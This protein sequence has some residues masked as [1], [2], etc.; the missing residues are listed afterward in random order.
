MQ[1]HQLA[2]AKSIKTKKRVG[3]GGKRGTYAGRGGKGQSARAGRNFRP[4]IRDVLKR[5]PKLRGHRNRSAANIVQAANLAVLEAKFKT[6]DKI[7]PRLLLEKGVICR[8][9]G[10][11]PQVKILGR[12]E[13]SKKFV[14]S[15][16]A[17][18]GT[19]KTKIEQ[20]GGKIKN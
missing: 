5:Y 18:S 11:L 10:R 8:V 20:S 1:I 7:S 2:K 3:R 13:I 9:S 6:G 12:G 17:V 16:C 19:A 4:I 14:I 15:G